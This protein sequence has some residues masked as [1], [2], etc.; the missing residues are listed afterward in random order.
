MRLILAAFRR[1]KSLYVMWTLSLSL[2]VSGLVIID[3]Y[4]HSLTAMVKEQGRKILTADVTLSSRRDLSEDEKT[5]STAPCLREAASRS[6]SRC[7]PWSVPKTRADSASCA[8]WT[9]SI[10]WSEICKSKTLTARSPTS[11]DCT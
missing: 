4:R 1:Q 9:I 5:V 10:L 2:A 6:S 8:S 11:A 3:V 7:S